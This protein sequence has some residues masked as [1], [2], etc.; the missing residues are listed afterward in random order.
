MSQ[1]SYLDLAMK[2]TKPMRFSEVRKIV[3]NIGFRKNKKKKQE[4]AALEEAFGTGN[5]MR[6]TDPRDREDSQPL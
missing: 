3:Q 4:E 5:T 2:Q 6:S 1:K